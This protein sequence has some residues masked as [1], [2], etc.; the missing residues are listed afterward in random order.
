MGIS[1]HRGITKV[2]NTTL[3]H[4]LLDCICY[5]ALTQFS[6][7]WFYII[8]LNL[9]AITF[10]CPRVSLSYFIL[11]VILHILVHRC[12]HNIVRLA[13]RIVFLFFSM[14]VVPNTLKACG[15]LLLKHFKDYILIDAEEMLRAHAVPEQVNQLS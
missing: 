10:T 9:P 4:P 1:R 15:F 7:T 8:T 11:V 2:L 14:L 12:L 13:S 6:G 5:H 3:S